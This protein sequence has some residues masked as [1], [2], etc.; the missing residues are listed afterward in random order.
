M[1]FFWEIESGKDTI[2]KY[3]SLFETS[4]YLIGKS[5]IDI[6][7]NFQ[8]KPQVRVENRI[9]H[10]V[11]FSEARILYLYTNARICTKEKCVRFTED[12]RNIGYLDGSKSDVKLKLCS[13][14]HS[15]ENFL[16]C[17]SPYDY[18]CYKVR[19]KFEGDCE[20]TPSSRKPSQSYY[21]ENDHVFFYQEG[22]Q[23][24]RKFYLNEKEREKIVEMYHP[25]D[26]PMFFWFL[27][28]V[29]LKVYFFVFHLI[30][31]AVAILTI[32]RKCKKKLR[33]LE[34]RELERQ[35]EREKRKRELMRLLQR[36]DTEGEQMNQ[37]VRF[38]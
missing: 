16:Y 34:E 1:V 35:S 25:D 23:I 20:L 3:S 4:P 10:L 27:K 21:F 15:V 24:S 36:E 14:I 18:S 37:R 32:V 22:N 26:D 8:N 17:G 11:K 2:D 30:V 28:H 29:H 6:K 38:G 33:E 31:W 19:E 12:L 5:E 7:D 13:G 9:A